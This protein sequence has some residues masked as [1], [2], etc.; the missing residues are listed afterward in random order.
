M[1]REAK[2]DL[3]KF[4]EYVSK[5]MNELASRGETSNNIITNVF[6]GYMACTDKRFVE[7]MDQCKDN[8]KE[9]EDITYQDIMLKAEKSIKPEL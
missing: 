9:G 4:N 8:Y 6:T 2:N 7:Y 1:I 3:I 5:L